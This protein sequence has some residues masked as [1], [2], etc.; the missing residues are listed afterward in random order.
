MFSERHSSKIIIAL[1]SLA[2]AACLFAVIFAPLFTDIAGGMTV[3]MEYETALFDTEDVIEVNIEMD[4]KSWNEMLANAM[5]EEYKDCNVTINGK[6]V[7]NVAIRPKGNTSLAA[8]ASDPDTDRFSFKLEFDHFVDGQTYCGLDKL[9]LNNNFAD[10]TNMKEA[11]VYDMYRYLDSDASLY[12]YAK[13]SV[14]GE[15]WGVYLALEG[16]EDSFMLRNYGTQDGE[17]Y[18][19]DPADV[20]REEP[21]GGQGMMGNSPEDAQQGGGPGGF[22]PT[23]N[24]GLLPPGPGDGGPGNMPGLFGM[25]PAPRDDSNISDGGGAS[26]NYTNDDLDSYP[27]IWGCEVTSTSKGDH[28]RVVTALK[29]VSEGKDIEKYIDVDNVLKYMAVHTFAVNMDSLSSD[30]THNYYLYEYEGRLNIFPWDYNLSFGGVPMAG[31][32]DGTEVIN[33]P[34]DTPFQGTSFFDALLENDEYCARYHAYLRQLADEYV[35]GGRF[36]ETYSRIRNRID[37]LVEED[38]T[39]FYSYGEYQTAADMLYETVKLRA[40]SIDGQLN[41]SVPSTREGQSLEP[42]ALVD[43]S[44]IDVVA[45]GQ[46]S[47]S[48]K[49]SDES[50]ERGEP[51]EGGGKEHKEPAEDGEK[52]HHGD[53]S[54]DSNAA[55]E[56]ESTDP[57][58]DNGGAGMAFP[59]PQGGVPNHPGPGN[60]PPS[61]AGLL[62]QSFTPDSMK[63]LLVYSGLLILMILA[64]IGIKHV[65]RR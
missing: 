15:Y 56:P 31:I 6:R 13:V 40:E 9:I 57:V 14:N 23:E 2:V 17:L 37:P 11:I 25:G 44:S 35:N 61:L 52:H 27:V 43:G 42:G 29:N 1:M 16:I 59:V 38:P 10:A 22:Q 36:D 60:P 34:I 45:M 39:S 49:N 28:R 48:G 33:Y 58:M 4:D 19:P 24:G 65:K 21:A 47:N 20:T 41:G 63:N 26:L 64:V 12:N 54:D 8:I 51:S 46:F 5:T 55:E 62:R 3:N 32:K 7:N 18:K 30:M 50:R 53:R